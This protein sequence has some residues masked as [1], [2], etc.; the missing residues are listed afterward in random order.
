MS[1]ISSDICPPGLQNLLILDPL[2]LQLQKPSMY[3]Y[4]VC[5]VQKCITLCISLAVASRAVA[6]RA[7]AWRAV[8]TRAVAWRAVAS[9]AVAWRAV[10]SRAVAL[11]A[12]ASRAVASSSVALAR[13]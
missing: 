7:V 10:G 8:A 5:T 1:N 4:C 13:V 12:V 3:R 9:R 6:S 2:H 11:C